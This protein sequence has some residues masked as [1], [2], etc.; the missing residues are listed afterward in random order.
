MLHV[1][2]NDDFAFLSVQ[3]ERFATILALDAFID[4]KTV[5]GDQRLAVLSFDVDPHPDAHI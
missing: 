2:V 1:N 4:A 3:L 5:A